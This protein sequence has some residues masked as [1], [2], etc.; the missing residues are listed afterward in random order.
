MVNRACDGPL[1]KSQ[2]GTSTRCA[3]FG[4]AHAATGL[5]D[6]NACFPKETRA[7]LTMGWLTRMGCGSSH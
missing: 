4:V 7:S 2:E 1:R 5:P 3:C 6:V